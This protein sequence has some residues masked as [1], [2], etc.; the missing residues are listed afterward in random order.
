MRKPSRRAARARPLAWRCSWRRSWRMIRAW[1]AVI[2]EGAAEPSAT[3]ARARHVADIAAVLR[4]HL[5]THAA[6][7][8]PHE[9]VHVRGCVMEGAGVEEVHGGLLVDVHIHSIC[10]H[11][12]CSALLQHCMNACWCEFLRNTVTER[13]PEHWGPYLHAGPQKGARAAFDTT[14]QQAWPC[15]RYHTYAQ[16]HMTRCFIGGSEDMARQTCGWLLLSW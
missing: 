13:I 3:A 10:M 5:A 16:V 12:C 6:G 2:G 7:R 9:G 1:A 14:L 4:D 11:A 15:W 8:L